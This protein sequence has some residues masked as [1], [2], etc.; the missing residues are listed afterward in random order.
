[1]KYI[2][3]LFTV[4]QCFST[5]AYA[6]TVYVTD[7]TKYALRSQESSRSKIVTML[8]T[9]AKLTVLS[10]NANSGYSR[11]KTPKGSEGYLLTRLTSE[12]P[13]SKWF[14]EKA[15]K[16]LEEIQQLNSSLSVKNTQLQSGD[17]KILNTNQSL[18]VEQDKLSKD[19]RDIR[20]TAANAIEI[21][22]QRDR[23]QER[24]IAVERELEQVKRKNHT[25]Q[26]NT[27][28]DWFLYGGMLALF[29]VML[30]IMLPKLN[31]GG[32]SGGSW[33]SF[34]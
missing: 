12:T 2:L 5:V 7:T 17:S 20:L 19:L 31:R 4:V 23:L 29:G 30:G 25:L 16:K 9:G 33:N 6:N 10:T 13:T 3:I 15:N 18:I 22:Q 8:P 24:I 21:K 28:Q 27:D 34:N 32:H 26:N 14:L 11:V 1:M